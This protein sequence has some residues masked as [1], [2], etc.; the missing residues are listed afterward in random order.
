MYTFG[1]I[2]A[3]IYPCIKLYVSIVAWKKNSCWL[4]G[5]QDHWYIN[6]RGLK[7]NPKGEQM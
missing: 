5:S 1:S 3:F 2:C 4:L 7:K 6:Q